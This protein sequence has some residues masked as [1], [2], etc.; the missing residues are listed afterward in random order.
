MSIHVAGRL[1]SLNI[2]AEKLAS[3]VLSFL[4]RHL[5]EHLF[6]RALDPAQLGHLH[7]R[8]HELTVD[9]SGGR[10]VR[11]QPKRAVEYLHAFRAE[12]SLG[13]LAGTAQWLCGDQER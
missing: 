2:S 3:I 9:P 1:Y 7:V 12:Q 10:W 13:A 6:Q 11:V 8:A 5:Q 4:V